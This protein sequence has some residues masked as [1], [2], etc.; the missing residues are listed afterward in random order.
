MQHRI[1]CAWSAFTKHRQE[2]T[3]QSCRLEHRLQLFDA[4]VTITYGAGT[5]ATA[6]EHEKMLRTSQRRLLRLFIQTRR[7][8]HKKETGGRDTRDDEI[9]EE[10]QEEISTHDDCDQDSTISFDDDEDS[11]TSHED[12]LEDWIEYVEKARKTIVKKSHGAPL[13]CTVA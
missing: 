13:S 12:N 3:S 2:L 5:W 8:K 11:T 10:S 7:Y 4:V 1:R 9:S 6:K